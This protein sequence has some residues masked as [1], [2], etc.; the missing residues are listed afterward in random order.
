MTDE[1]LSQLQLEVNSITKSNFFPN[2]SVSI[3]LTIAHLD[4][5]RTLKQRAGDKISVIF[6][7]RGTLWSLM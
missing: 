1:K 3:F 2:T 4:L 7:G 5:V 6:Y